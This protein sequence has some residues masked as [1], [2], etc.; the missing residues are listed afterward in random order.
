MQLL[1]AHGNATTNRAVYSIRC[2]ACGFSGPDRS[3]TAFPDVWFCS[4]EDLRRFIE[5]HAREQQHRKCPEC[6]AMAGLLGLRLFVTAGS[7]RHDLVVD[8][9]DGSPTYALLAPDGGIELISETDPRLRN[10]CLDSCLR[11]GQFLAEVRP[12]D[13]QEAL[14]LL[15]STA[16][17]RPE[18]PESQLALARV[19]LGNGQGPE[20]MSRIQA[21]S[22]HADGNLAACLELGALLGELSTQHRDA[23]LLNIA[24]DWYDQ[25]LSLDPRNPSAHLAVG[26]L[27][28]QTG[29]FAEAGPHL[30]VA[31]QSERHAME[32]AY[33]LGLLAMHT[34]R[35]ADAVLIFGKLAEAAPQDGDIHRMRAWS[36]AKCGRADEALRVL[37]IAE[38][39]DP[40]NEE[41]AHF[42]QLIES[43]E[44]LE[45]G[46]A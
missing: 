14:E 29:N 31:A 38:Q 32:A 20:A 45:A 34:G 5:D 16:D 7:L 8:Q 3:F 6:N 11:A 40:R 1:A 42:R 23:N 35:P 10:V 36:L 18:D 24:L 15:R 25:A 13:L 19:L 44:D 46:G 9:S 2:D 41:T 26:R 12:D 30:E 21:A 39:V 28:L 43:G 17:A 33:N 37:D 22:K 27:F 4:P